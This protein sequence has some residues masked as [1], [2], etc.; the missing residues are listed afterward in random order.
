MISALDAS[1][2]STSSVSKLGSS[3]FNAFANFLVS[4]Q[5]E[6]LAAVEVEDG[7]SA[8][9]QRDPWNRES[10]GSYGLTTC[11]EDGDLVEK[12]AASVSI[13]HGVLTDV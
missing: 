8:R 1:Q 3:R 12:G 9:F 6:I 10:D 2:R 5:N 7:G 4:K 13:I 11:L